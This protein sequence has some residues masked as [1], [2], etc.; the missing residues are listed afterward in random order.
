LDLK[1]RLSKDSSVLINK[2]SKEIS[3][4][5]YEKLKKTSASIVFML[6]NL[7]PQKLVQQ[8]KKSRPPFQF[9]DLKFHLPFV[10]L[11]SE[12]KK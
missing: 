2:L 4:D 12:G 6:I 7:T 8:S 10:G 9:P 3:D 11:K 1:T 5:E